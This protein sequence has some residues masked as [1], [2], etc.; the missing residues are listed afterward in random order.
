[1]RLFLVM[2]L[3]ASVSSAGNLLR[4]PGFEEVGGWEAHES[5]ELRCQW[6]S[7]SG[8]RFNA[9]L[10]GRWFENGLNAMVEQRDVPVLAGTEYEFRA[11]VWA[12]MGWRPNEQ[13]MKVVF[14]D[15]EQQAVSEEMKPLKGLHPVWSPVLFRVRAPD[16]A[17]SASVALVAFEIS[18]YG[19]LTIDDVY[20][21]PVENRQ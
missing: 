2:V 12:D 13:F 1:M 20:F 9:A 4:N 11:W 17:V 10:Q 3:F 5:A 16:R 6:R 15:A 18:I 19:A 8:G 21:G 7:R 14:Y